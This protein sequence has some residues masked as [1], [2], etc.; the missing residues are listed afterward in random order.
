MILAEFWD[1]VVSWNLQAKNWDWILSKCSLR[2]PVMGVVEEWL[3]V[4]LTI[5]AVQHSIP[6]IAPCYIELFRD[7]SGEYLRHCFLS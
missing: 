5:W 3:S 1:G 7:P 4:M 2:L 6:A